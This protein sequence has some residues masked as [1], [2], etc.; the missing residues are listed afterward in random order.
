VGGTAPIA[1][2]NPDAVRPVRRAPRVAVIPV[3]HQAPPR[4]DPFVMEIISGTKKSETK[5]DN[6]GEGK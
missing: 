3:V 1:E 6:G 4:K 5:F 2:A